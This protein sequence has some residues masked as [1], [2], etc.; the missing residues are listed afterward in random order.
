ML[1]EDAV[2]RTLIAYHVPREVPLPAGRS[3]RLRFSICMHTTYPTIHPPKTQM[4]GEEEDSEEE[5]RLPVA[6]TP[7]ERA[8]CSGLHC[9]LAQVCIALWLAQAGTPR[10][11]L[12]EHI[13]PSAPLV[14]QLSNCG[15]NVVAQ[16]LRRSRPPGG[17]GW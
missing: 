12:N 2:R 1:G 13:I 14:A 16:S 15:K 17:S 5:K 7:A 11:E 10:I 6:S 3:S 9:P 8:A 4:R